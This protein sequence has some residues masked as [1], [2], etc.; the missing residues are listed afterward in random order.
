MPD[1]SKIPP[2]KDGCGFG[3]YVIVLIL[4]FMLLGGMLLLATKPLWQ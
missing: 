4:A 1:P 2:D 3:Y